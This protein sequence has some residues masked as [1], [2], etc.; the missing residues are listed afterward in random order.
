MDA[1]PAQALT[2]GLITACNGMP[3]FR[4]IHDVKQLRDVSEYLIRK[5]EAAR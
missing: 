4:E 2:T 5:V 3:K 1:L